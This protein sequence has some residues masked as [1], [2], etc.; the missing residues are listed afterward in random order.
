VA[1]AGSAMLLIAVER[2]LLRPRMAVAVTSLACAWVV[3]LALMPSVFDPVCA[4]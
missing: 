1:I 2:H 4:N 3:V